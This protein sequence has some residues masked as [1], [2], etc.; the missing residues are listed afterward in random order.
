M[1]LRNTLLSALTAFA[2]ATPASAALL[3]VI[4]GPSTLGTAATIIA[5]PA[6]VGDDAAINTGLQGFNEVIGHVLAAAVAV[7]GGGF[8]A[9][10]TRVDSHMIFLNTEGNVFNEANAAW[11]F[12]GIILGTMQDIGGNDEAASNAFL[13][14][15]GTIYPGAFANRGLEG[16]DILF[17]VG[18]VL[19]TTFKVTEPGDWIRVV[20]VS[21]V[22]LPAALPLFAGGL[23]LMGLFS[24]RKK[25]QAMAA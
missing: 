7:S 22:P 5:A 18:N 9:A 24:R 19:T 12:D 2:L 3:S 21:A 23:G 1:K 14:N 11:T 25:R 4:G 15:P 17:F 16:N 10:G 8:I 13:G 6:D 20:T